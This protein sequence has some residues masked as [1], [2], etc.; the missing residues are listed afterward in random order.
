MVVSLFD[1]T[2]FDYFVLLLFHHIFSFNQC[3]YIFQRSFLLL[4]DRAALA[5][6]FF[7]PQLP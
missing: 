7:E 4:K 5:L 1:T 2:I 3:K 6:L